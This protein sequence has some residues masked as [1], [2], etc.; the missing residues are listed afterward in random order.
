MWSGINMHER[1]V[2]NVSRIEMPGGWYM[3]PD[4]ETAIESEYWLYDEQHVGI[5]IAAF[6]KEGAE[7]FAAAMNA[8]RPAEAALA[9][10]VERLRS[11]LMKVMSLF[12]ADGED[13]NACLERLAEEFWKETGMLAPFKDQSALDNSTTYDERADAYAA[14]R[15]AKVVAGFAALAQ[16]KQVG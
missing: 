9:A 2:W 3:K 11:G 10:E 14:W 15:E 7:Q 5:M 6:E 13:S 12:K 16:Q 4:D 8:P 1:E